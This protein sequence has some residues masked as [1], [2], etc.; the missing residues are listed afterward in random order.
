M[1]ARQKITLSLLLYIALCNTAFAQ[2]ID[3]PDP[4]RKKK[5][6]SMSTMI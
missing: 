3:I 4:S 2:V 5:C 6:I 1:N